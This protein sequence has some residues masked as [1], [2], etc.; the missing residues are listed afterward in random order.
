M[1]RQKYWGFEYDK[2]INSGEANEKDKYHRLARQHLA[3]Q[4]FIENDLLEA[5]H[6]NVF[7]SYRSLS[8]YIN[9]WCTASIIEH[10]LKLNENFH[11]YNKNI[12]PGLTVENKVKQ[13]QFSQHVHNLWGLP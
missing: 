4:P 9:E 10:W 5:Q 3:R 1:A 2:R 8:R 11:L 6:A 13:V 7:T 12:K